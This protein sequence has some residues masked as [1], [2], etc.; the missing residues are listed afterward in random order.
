MIEDN[1]SGMDDDDL[2][3]DDQYKQG[4]WSGVSHIN[5]C[6]GIGIKITK[7]VRKRDEDGWEGRRKVREGG[8]KGYRPEPQEGKRKA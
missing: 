6:E 2:R 4:C 5:M 8:A 7:N 3:R 1:Q